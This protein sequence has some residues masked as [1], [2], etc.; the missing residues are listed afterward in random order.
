M[1]AV[2][3]IEIE[4]GETLQE[5][6][7]KLTGAGTCACAERA[8][9]AEPKA[10]PK[11][12][13]KAKPSPKAKP[14]FTGQDAQDGVCDAEDVAPEKPEVAFEDVR[15]AASAAMN[16]GKR[17]EVEALIVELSDNGKLTGVD[18]GD[19]PALLEKVEAL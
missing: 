7:A 9:K 17:S 19:Y 15:A 3:N 18:A 5:A 6:L 11:P 12:K 1:R 4:S 14:A 16:R 10:G 13:A 2:I 8:P